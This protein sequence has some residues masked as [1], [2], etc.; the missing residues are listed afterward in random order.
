MKYTDYIQAASSFEAA[1]PQS[2]VQIP[3]LESYDAL[4]LTHY[5]LGLATEAVEL[6][7]AVKTKPLVEQQL[8]LSDILWFSAL[9]SNALGVE[10]TDN[11]IANNR[12][13]KHGVAALAN[14]CEEFASRIKAALIYGTPAKPRD[15]DEFAWAQLPK[16]I[17][18]HACAIGDAF[19]GAGKLMDLNI[20]K[21]SKRYPKGVFDAAAAVNRKEWT[22]PSAE[23]VGTVKLPVK[24]SELQVDQA[25]IAEVLTPTAPA[26]IIEPPPAKPIGKTPEVINLIN[27]TKPP[28]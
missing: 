10:I 12:S 24:V 16:E 8:E 5:A 20:S 25:T 9:A 22:K 19:L 6:L 4:K 11:E 18:L 14:K 23:L 1:D 2:A 17:F 27:M 13:P 21:L 7:D 26:R 15:K 3:C 28:E